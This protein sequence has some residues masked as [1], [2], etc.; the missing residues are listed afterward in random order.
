M[1]MPPLLCP[2][3]VDAPASACAA[4][5]VLGINAHA[6]HCMRGALHHMC[7]RV[8][9]GIS[10]NMRHGDTQEMDD[11]QQLKAGARL[12]PAANLVS[13]QTALLYSSLPLHACT[14]LAWEVR[15]AT[16]RAQNVFAVLT[17]KS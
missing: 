3:A 6:V 9:A 12:E 13:G 8:R 10:A 5:S 15:S 16:E 2:H 17:S 11:Q 1:L 7:L 4:C 14:Y